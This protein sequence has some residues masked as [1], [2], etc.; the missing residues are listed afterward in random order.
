[1]AENAVALE[2]L[3]PVGS[4]ACAHRAGDPVPYETTL[5]KQRVKEQGWDDKIQKPS[6]SDKAK[7]N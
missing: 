1:M 3:Y 2:D 7:G 6:S 5:D 4:W